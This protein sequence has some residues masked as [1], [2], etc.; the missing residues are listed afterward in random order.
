MKKLL[1]SI[2]ALIIGMLPLLEVY[3]QK[4]V[5][6]YQ[7][8]VTAYIS[9]PLAAITVQNTGGTVP[10]QFNPR[11]VTLISTS[12]TSWPFVAGSAGDVYAFSNYQLFHVAANG[13]QT[14]LA[15]STTSG[16]VDGTGA[17]AGFD[18]VES[19]AI[20]AS[21]N[22]FTLED[23]F[24]DVL[25]C[26]VRKVTPDG[27]VTT[28]AGGLRSPTALTVA[29][30]GM[31]YVTEA[32]GRIMQV[33][34]NGTTSL[35]A[36]QLASGN[37][38]GTGA[39]A[40]FNNPQGITTDVSGNIY[41]A[42]FGNSLIRKITP[43]GTVTTLAG[44]R[45][46]F[47]S[48]DGQGTAA[49]FFNPRS[50]A[51]DSKGN[52]RVADQNNYLIRT[53][54]LSGA[55]TTLAG[56]NTY[57]VNNQSLGVNV[58]NQFVLD[59]ND[60]II[61]AGPYTN[62]YSKM[63]TTGF[64]ISP[65]LPQ[66]MV[67]NP[68]G[69][70]SGTPL[71][72]SAAKDYTVKAV[73]AN[74][75]AQTVVNL[76]VVTP[77]DP[78]VITSFS[79]AS[80]PAG[81]E[82]DITGNYFTGTTAVSIG[83]KPASNF[84]V[85]SPTSIAAIVASGASGSNVTVTNPN[86]TSTASGFNL[87]LPPVI[88]SISP[89]SAWKGATIT[90]KG[91]NL[92]GASNVQIGGNYA[93]SFT[94]VSSTEI[95]ATVGDASSGNVYVFTPGGSVT[96][97]GF[98]FIGPPTIS[99]VN[100]A[101]AIKGAT[102]TITGNNFA[103][104]TAVKFGGTD[105]ASFT[106][107]SPT[108]ITAVLGA[109]A[110]G[111]VSVTTGAGTASWNNFN[112][113]ASPVIAN[114]TPI[115][116]GDGSNIT[117][118][119]AGLSNAQVT[120][121]GVP[122]AV[123]YNTDNLILAT[124]GSGATSGNIVVTTSAGSASLTGF[125][126]V[127]APQITSFTPT[128][129]A[130]GDIVTL[131][132]SN[133][134][135]VNSVYFGNV[136]AA[137]TVISP[138][139]IKATVGYGASG[140]VQVTSP[141]GNASLAGFTHL[142]PA[143]TSF[144][145]A[146]GGPGQV[147]AITGNNFTG[148]TEVDFGGVPAASFTVVS[149]TLI[150]ATV[151]PGTSGYITVTTPLG[152]AQMAGF[153]HPGPSVL[154]VSPGYAGPLLTTP[155]LISGANF[156]NV[157]SVTFGGVPAASYTVLSQNTISATP[158]N[159]AS[160]DVVVT[161]ALGSGRSTGFIWVQAPTITA[162]SPASAQNGATITITGTNFT[163]VSAVT[164]GGVNTPHNVVN[165]TTISAVVVNGASGNINVVTAGGTATF[166]GFS[167]NSPLIQSISPTIAA[168][169][170][171]VTITGVNLDATNSVSF[172]NTPAASFAIVSPQQITAVVGAGTTGS[173]M[174]GGSKGTASIAGFTFL[175]P[176]VITS[177]T[178]TQ[179][180]A[181]TTVSINGG[182]LLTTSS[183]TI[184]GVRAAI[185]SVTN[186]TVQVKAGSGATGKISLT[187]SAGSTEIDG[188]T[189]YPAPVISS[190]DPMSGNSQSLI[191]ITG[192]NFTGVTLVQ[193][194]GFYVGFTIVSP[195]VITATP[196]AGNGGDITVTGPGGT[197][198]LPG[199]VFLQAPT[200]TSFVTS[201]EGPGSIVTISGTN[202]NQVS[203]VEFGGLP[204]K[205]YTVTAPGTIVASPGTGATGPITV[206]TNG[207]IASIRGYLYISP[208]KVISFFPLSARAGSSLTLT[209]DHFNTNAG[210]NVVFI[211]PVQGQVTAA[212]STQLVVNVPAGA[213][214]RIIVENLDTRLSGC[215]NLPFF[216]SNN[217]GKAAFPSKLELTFS[218]T[219]SNYAIED[220]DGDNKPDL[221]I[222][223]EDSLYILRNSGDTILSAGSF[224]QKI[225]LKLG[226]VVQSM[227]VGDVDGDGKKDI[228]ISIANSVL[229]LHN[230]SSGSSLSFDTQTMTGVGNSLDGMALSDV[231]LD[232]R[233]DLII[234]GTD[235]TYYPNTTTAG[236]ISF[237]PKV[238]LANSSSSSNISFAITDIDGDN[239]P[240]PINGSSY[241]GFSIF[242]NMSVP[243]SLFSTDFPLTYFSNTGYFYTPYTILATDFD[244]DQKP[245]ILE[246]DFS[247]TNFLIRRNIS[248]P[249]NLALQAPQSFNSSYAMKYGPVV[250]DLDGD[251]K[252]DLVS[253][254][255]NTIYFS[256]N[257]SAPGTI[258]FGSAAAVIS[259]KTGDYLANY[260][261]ADF[262][263]DGRQ[264][265]ALLDVYN[266][267]LTIYSN[268]PPAVPVITDFT[269]K[270]AGTSQKVTIAGKYF[271]GATSVKFGSKDAASFTVTSSG[272][273][274]AL[275]GDGE[276]GNVTVQTPL[277]TISMG[278]F[279]YIA[280][281]V[282]SLVSLPS[283][284][285]TTVTISGINFIGTTG[286]AF[287]SVPVSSFNV[288]SNTSITAVLDAINDGVLT[289]T[290][291]LGV[292][293]FSI[294]LNVSAVITFPAIPVKTYGDPDFSLAV[295]SNNTVNPVTFSVD[296]P[297]LAT[298][299]D[300]TVHIL[301]AGTV[302]ITASQAAGGYYQSAAPLA[303]TLN[304]QKRELEIKADTATR[305]FGELN[306]HFTV[307][308]TGFTG[309][310]SEGELIT[311]PTVST[312][313][314]ANSP[315]GD[316]DLL[317]SG[318][319]SDNYSFVYIKGTLTITPARDNFKLAATGVTCRGENNGS[320]NITATQPDSYQAQV[321]GSG[322]NKSYAFSDTL[323][324]PGL[325]PGSYNV[326]LGDAKIPGYQQCFNLNI[327]EPKDLSVYSSVNK[328]DNVVTLNLSG[329]STYSVH[330]N[331]NTYT[332]AGPSVTLPLDRGV[333]KLSVIT[334][335]L[336]QGTYQQ[337]INSGFV[338][339]PN[340]FQS[341]LSVDLGSKPL[342]GNI[343][344]YS[345]GDGYLRF[346]QSFNNQTGVLSL[347]L[348][349]LDIGAYSMYIYADNKGNIYKIVKQ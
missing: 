234:G 164:I 233:P 68:D 169:G 335:K 298:I 316:Y 59:K 237:G 158:N 325:A 180:G 96:F 51:C 228:L 196:V 53:I 165:A 254:S 146:Q 299:S 157:T 252:P 321:S 343:K 264:D 109:G 10:A 186:N 277:G 349:R 242:Q 339:Y 117:I 284:G 57:D 218:S 257:H 46:T 131:T 313:A 72:L 99:S 19:L 55:V 94:V 64:S 197:A 8:P 295:T 102:V 224:A 239:K 258:S 120:I 26:T 25:N 17:S 208:P 127:T 7:G 291:P 225:D 136:S 37:A 319:A 9:K 342:T 87:I 232:G 134:T 292:G 279:T 188:F 71:S 95:T 52:L 141:G 317:P 286:V 293:T 247:A 86:G 260:Q 70:I 328:A 181:G 268:S 187:T 151:G 204:A 161:T 202:F 135:S 174:V 154:S 176:P 201:G 137:F 267:K 80:A 274:D 229:L 265:V 315:V 320:I 74:G 307:S 42:D 179:G 270:F 206:T 89:T 175:P 275:V 115:Q 166:S 255:D 2:V 227:V 110:S 38:D 311:K 235:P 41:V 259:G 194:G 348:S 266:K 261:F 251:G 334:D 168:V 305:A 58:P 114:A 62:Q 262:D 329:A 3:A 248:T 191:T 123:T 184:G 198:T 81:A 263:G 77:T 171:T 5:I 297:A 276:S 347:D 200:I 30:N 122:A 283:D 67:F 12:Y 326:C 100:P 324:I 155:V 287:G 49:T 209:G 90:I 35:L 34:T 272:T 23:N 75:V 245:D 73:N 193:F 107:V 44:S 217:S 140:A 211:G 219:P 126:F 301:K 337:T 302:T 97:P 173:V 1:P 82:I 269:P 278:G 121:G 93:Y 273:I 130:Q 31:I 304:I 231:N 91:T 14:L 116:A 48:A 190:A 296:N 244:G 104:A 309:S 195:T 300:G 207:G 322:L 39:A 148:T 205:S 241:S 246:N 256:P 223:K 66:G 20:D 50:V 345:L 153:T 103:N 32:S 214:G 332:T 167:N 65:A 159:G 36:G 346:Q 210:R 285:S 27:K 22:I 85:N 303:Q 132:G 6:S 336:C 183:V 149:A 192:T 152:K 226:R 323:N 230:T 111:Q 288:L 13:T 144:T 182:N 199:F 11:V 118:S 18:N 341:V 156:T 101:S 105:A 250:A 138:T 282:I 61:Y 40:S 178:P 216:I 212:T 318:T 340:S 92:T 289:V 221:L 142:G 150:N 29:A 106:V 185:L 84:S 112:F 83:G 133:F 79:P 294:K 76:Q 124:V 108:S 119:G 310:D 162:I 60:N 143:I 238:Y 338:P 177:F 203:D 243:G 333:N 290:T 327:T 145:P 45:L 253:S 139:S 314:T 215:S 21:G 125:V 308:Y 240:D 24:Q 47:G 312:I 160:G 15:G 4:P 236:I 56:P 54:T 147:V 128:T 281:P 280:Q 78:P 331:N 213:S 271:D 222:A 98:V 306:P 63:V 69:S 113:I 170:Q 249:G 163:G 220:F 129:A 16:S 28:Y 189:W 88:T 344:I 43:G 172:G 330:I 33:S